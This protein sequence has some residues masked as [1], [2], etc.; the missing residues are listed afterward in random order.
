MLKVELSGITRSYGRSKVCQNVNLI[1]E[2]GSATALTGPN[3][4]G[5]STLLKIIAGFTT[6]Q[7]GSIHWSLSDQNLSIADIPNH[8]SFCSPATLL[9]ASLTVEETIRLHFTLRKASIPESEVVKHLQLPSKKL[10]PELSSGMIQRLKLGLALFTQSN[11]LLLDEPTMNLDSSWKKEYLQWIAPF[12]G[13]RTIVIASND[14]SE[15]AFCTRR[16]PL[17]GG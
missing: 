13:K 17:T 14:E 8:L 9:P 10:L 7:Q 11:L 5:K 2:P 6:P 15:Y 1:L 16:F 3:G 4:S 12:L